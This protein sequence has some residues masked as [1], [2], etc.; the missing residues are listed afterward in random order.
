VPDDRSEIVE[1]FDLH[2]GSA[3]PASDRISQGRD[4]PPFVIMDRWPWWR[5]TT[6][7]TH[8][9]TAVGVA[10]FVTAAVAGYGALTAHP[11][12]QYFVNQETRSAPRVTVDAL[13]CPAT[14]TCTLV[15]VPAPIVA[16]VRHVVPSARITY[17]QQSVDARSGQV[18]RREIDLSGPQM[19]MRIVSQCL[20]GAGPVPAQPVRLTVDTGTGPEVAI[21][22]DP[23]LT[24]RRRLTQIVPGAVG[25]SLSTEAGTSRSSDRLDQKSMKELLVLIAADPALM[26]TR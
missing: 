19:T 25:C 24:G 15:V 2:A 6:T 10:G 1:L 17:A 26:V 14:T 23:T 9:L 3:T 20:P 18:F 4:R 7:L 8:A 5:R 11:G 13:G 16:D 21:Q 12:T 22:D